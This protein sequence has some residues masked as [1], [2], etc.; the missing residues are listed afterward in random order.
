MLTKIGGLARSLYILLAI[1]AGFVAMGGMNV[2]LVLVVLGLISGSAM[3]RERLVL[4]LAAVIALPLIGTALAVIP[5]IGAQLGAVMANL[6][7]G[8]AG[9]AAT[10]HG[11]ASLRADHGGRYRTSRRRKRDRQQGH[12]V[13]IGFGDIVVRCPQSLQASAALTSALARA[14][15]IWV[16][17]LTF[18]SAMTRPMSFIDEAPVSAMIDWIAALASASLNLGRQ[19]ALDHGDLGLFRG[20]Q[21]LAVALAVELDRFAALLDHLL[22][23]FGDQRVVVGLGRSGAQFDVAV[24]DRRLDQPDRLGRGLVAALHRANQRSLDVVA[25]HRASR[26]VQPEK[27][28]PSGEFAVSQR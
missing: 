14:G 28:S 3:P 16:P 7:L 26:L 11:D 22:Q 21:L 4:A 5:A 23:H 15:S 13:N 24:L 18:T 6:Q 17:S 2:A 25:N 12:R 27:P 1:I 8:V 10:A 19:E 9:A 20:G